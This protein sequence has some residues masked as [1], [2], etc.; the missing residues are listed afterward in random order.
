MWQPRF[1][2]MWFFVFTYVLTPARG[3]GERRI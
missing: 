3:M 2:V 1:P